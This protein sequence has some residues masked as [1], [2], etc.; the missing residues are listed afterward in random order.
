M[1]CLNCGNE[2]EGNFCPECGQKADM[3]RFT[4]KFIF[5]NLAAAIVSRDG[6]I[7]F[8]L[9]NLFTRPGSMIVD[10]LGGKRKKYFSPFPMLFFALTLYI[11]ITSFTSG[12]VLN[13]AFDELMI[14]DMEQDPEFGEE[15]HKEATMAFMRLFQ[16]GVAFFSNHYTLCYLLT[17]PLL[18]VAARACFGKSNRKRYY[19]AEYIIAVVYASVIVVLFRCL[20]KLVYPFAPDLSMTIGF[21][22]APLVIIPALTACFRKMLGFNVAKTAW[23]STLTF[24]L[25]YQMLGVLVLIGIVVLAII[26]VHKNG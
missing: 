26:Y 18:V 16:Q 12:F 3:G 6:S 8:T 7:W 15:A 5:E 9:K 21:L 17:L 10:M 14:T 11:V 13:D 2:F 25:Y 1:K 23:R 4:M 19:W 22:V 24:I 20:V